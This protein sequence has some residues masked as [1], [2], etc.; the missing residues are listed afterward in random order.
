MECVDCHMGAE[1]DHGFEPATS[2]CQGCHPSATSFDYKRVQTVTDSLA[3]ELGEL[4][5]A[6]GLIDENSPDGH[7]IVNSAPED[8]GIALW[9]WLYVAH[10]DQSHGVHNPAYTRALLEEGLARMASSVP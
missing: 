3:F 8:Q 1:A 6:A 5:L 4:L 2:T 9:N 7:P 10:E